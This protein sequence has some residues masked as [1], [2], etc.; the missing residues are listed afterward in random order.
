MIV[1]DWNIRVGDCDDFI[2]GV[3]NLT[4]R[5]IIDYKTNQHC[6]TL[7]DFLISANLCILNGRNTVN[8]DYTSISSRGCAVVDYC[9][10]PYEQLE[11]YS[12]FKVTRAVDLINTVLGSGS[13]DNYHIPDH[14]FLTW[15]IKLKPM[16]VYTQHDS[17][18]DTCTSFVRYNRTNIPEAFLNDIETL[19]KINS[20]I[21]HL[22]QNQNEQCGIDQSYEDFIKIIKSQMSCHLNPKTITV[23]KCRK[24][25]RM[26][27]PWWSEELTVLW[28]K[29]CKNERNWLKTKNSND[30]N[31]L[32]HTYVQ[33]RKC[34]DKTVQKHKRQ[35]WREMQNKL[36]ESCESPNT[37]EFWKTIG[38]VGL[39][40]E[41]NK[42]IPMETINTD[43]TTSSRKSDVLNMWKNAFEQLFTCN[44]LSRENIKYSDVNVNGNDNNLNCGITILEVRRT[45]NSLN[46][47]K[48]PGYD[49]IPSEV[50][51]SPL[52]IKYLHR[53]FCVCFE[54]GKIPQSW[55]YGIITPVLKNAAS[56]ARDPS[57]Y[58]GITVTSAIYKAY[59]SVLNERLT[60]WIEKSAIITDTQNGFRRKRSTIDQLSTLTNIVEC[61]KRLRKPT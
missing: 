55:T 34:F 17:N 22:E 7:I 37:S 56:E 25:K 39:G 18:D 24:K 12:E 40:T 47:N 58:R 33:S 15:K 11:K 49:E 2:T 38:H 53:L 28:E 61:R 57:N 4:P 29:M 10:V 36:L 27:K 14:S 13:L 31:A 59:C 42:D 32:K 60:T 20:K 16:E 30:K 54:T 43:G 51:Q 26:K 5:T 3:D 48:S 44:D 9:F 19:E 45:I 50:I 6:E 41:R 35:Y 21:V 1:G 8:N 46:K 23:N 52:C